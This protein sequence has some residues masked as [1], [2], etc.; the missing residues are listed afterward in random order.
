M[1]SYKETTLGLLKATQSGIENWLIGPIS[2]LDECDL[3]VHSRKHVHRHFLT[4]AF[5]SVILLPSYVYNM[6]QD[7][8]SARLIA[9]CKRTLMLV[10]I[11]IFKNIYMVFPIPSRPHRVS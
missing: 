2:Y 1:N 4:N 7:T 3:M 10:S 5:C 9:V 8:K 11:R 6:H